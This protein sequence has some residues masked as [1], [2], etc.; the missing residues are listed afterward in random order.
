MNNI[1]IPWSDWKIVRKIG[2]G[3]YG[4]AYEISRADVFGNEERA[5]L[6]IIS[7]P[8]EPQ[9]INELR[10]DGYDQASIAG[11]YREQLERIVGEYNLQVQMKGNSHVISVEDRAVVPHEDGLGW[12]I[13]IRMELL[14]PMS[15]VLAQNPHFSETQ[16]IKLGRDICRALAICHEKNIIHRD[17]KPDNIFLNDFGDWKIGDFGLARTLEHTT[18]ATKAGTFAYMAPEVYHG[19]KYG[20]E[21][22]IYSLGMVLYWLLNNRRRPFLPLDRPPTAAEEEYARKQR[23]SPN[24]IFPLPKNG[25]PTLKDIV[26]RATAYD[27]H[28]RYQDAGEMLFELNHLHTDGDICGDDWENSESVVASDISPEKFSQMNNSH[29]NEEEASIGGPSRINRN[30][31]TVSFGFYSFSKE[32]PTGKYWIGLHDPRP[33]ICTVIKEGYSEALE[34]GGLR[35][36]LDDLD[37]EQNVTI[38]DVSFV[39][40]PA[41]AGIL[42]RLNVERMCL[43]AGIGKP[44]RILR[45]PSLEAYGNVCSRYGLRPGSEAGIIIRA[46]KNGVEF[47]C[48]D[49]GDDV[50][51]LMNCRH[52]QWEKGS[53]DQI[54]RCELERLWKREGVEEYIQSE[55]LTCKVVLYSGY[56]IR[57]ECLRGIRDAIPEVEVQ[58]ADEAGATD[59]AAGAAMLSAKLEKGGDYP[60]LL[61]LTTLGYEI[62]RENETDPLVEID[63]E[64]SIPSRAPAVFYAKNICREMLYVYENGKP[65][66]IMNPSPDLICEGSEVCLSIEIEAGGQVTWKKERVS[67]KAVDPETAEL[68]RLAS[69]QRAKGNFNKEKEFLERAYCRLYTP[70]DEE[71]LNR[72]G[73]NGLDRKDYEAALEY[74]EEAVKRYPDHPTAYVNASSVYARKKEYSAAAKMSKKGIECLERAPE[75]THVS[76]AGALYANA[77]Y[78]IHQEDRFL[79]AA[80]LRKAAQSGY[81]ITDLKKAMKL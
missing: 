21:V 39:S 9:E 40:I 1:T 42:D 77:A 81:D 56:E 46:G 23:F 52:F 61:D 53:K 54:V 11:R 66:G 5:A 32:D 43:E 76:K 57:E 12:D 28:K 15:E 69:E 17:I 47:T 75:Y 58:L 44:K 59:A 64:S 35:R 20:K 68:L 79:A 78:A 13:F 62:R 67:N 8:Q 22:D 65:C 45:T 10:M 48:Y 80:W 74:F 71:I 26:L 60:L 24:A 7:I 14:H 34:N 73:R 63:R 16:I 49:Y 41:T 3:G 2:R 36:I 18:A 27:P 19:E 70:G 37:R 6:K 33:E 31:R 30:L 29:M 50:M 72:C 4:T 55:N 25:S 38:T 51:E